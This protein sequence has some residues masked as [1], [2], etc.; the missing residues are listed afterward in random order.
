MQPRIETLEEKKLVGMRTKMSYS[1]NTTYQ[2][3]K[4]FRSRIDEVS[5]K[6]G[7]DFY[8]IQI[9]DENFFL[10]VNPNREF[11][12]LAAIEVSNLDKISAELEPLI[13]HSGHYAVFDYVGSSARAAD[14][15]Q[16]HF[17]GMV[18]KRNLWF[19]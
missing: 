13:L 15:F 4:T 11:E 8:S 9:Y 1:N 5:N 3:W 14:V 19:R 18:A 16:V 2:L 17:R 12:K 7:S 6:I 10:N